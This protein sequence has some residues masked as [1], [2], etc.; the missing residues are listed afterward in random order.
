MPRTSEASRTTKETSIQ[1]RLDLDGKG[2]Y[3]V[4]TGIPM[5]NHLLSQLARHGGFDLTVRAEAH[6]DPDG[7]HLTED[8]AI[9]LGRAFNEA[10]GE[11]KGIRRMES[12]LL[13]MDD[14]LAQAAVDLAGRG[15][16][17]LDIPFTTAEIGGL[18]TEMVRHFLES[19]AREA[20]ITIHVRLLDGWN[21]HHMAEAGFK[22]LARALRGAVSADPLLDGQAAST[23]G[24]L[25]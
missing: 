11:R 5:L 13:P 6:D 4:E 18:R 25:D 2:V 21:D 12:A 24:T 19:F 7:H 15:Y 16:V 3:Q 22:A 14:A 10:L 20:R 1:V 9:V 23:K 8:V 17:S